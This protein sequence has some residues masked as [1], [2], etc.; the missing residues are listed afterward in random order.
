MGRSKGH[1]RS[2]KAALLALAT[3]LLLL[4]L[5][6]PAQADP[7]A[8]TRA[9]ALDVPNLNH[10]CGAA[11]DKQG[12]L[13]ASSAGESKVKVYD[14]AD[15]TTP[16]AE[17]ANANTPCALAVTTTGALY[18][19]E[20]ATGNVVRY[21]PTA[22]P[23]EA[24]PIYGPAEPIHTDG[25]A[26]GIA[27][28]PFDNR[29]FVA[30]GDRIALYKADGTLEKA[31]LLEGQLTEATGVA[32]YTNPNVE[33]VAKLRLNLAVADGAG[34]ELEIY[35]GSSSTLSL[36]LRKTVTGVDH[37]DNPGT[38]EQEFSFGTAGAY[39][40]ADRG[41]ENTADGKCI[42]V[43]VGGQDQACT[44][45]HFFLHD[46][47]NEAIDEFGASGEFFAQLTSS[48]LE[49]A[50]PTQVAVERSGGANDGTLYA[51]SGS[52]AG[53]SLL[54]FAPVFEP[55]RQSLPAPFSK[56]L[57]SARAVAVDCEGFVYVAAG[58]LVRVYS[59]AGAEVV[60]FEVPSTTL[61]LAADCSG[62]VYVVNLAATEMTYYPPSS[63]PPSGSTTYTRHTP[64]LVTASG[65]SGV[66]V[67]PANEHAF[68]V[69]GFAFTP[70]IKEFAPPSESS[71]VEGECGAGLGLTNSRQDID[72]YGKNGNVYVT[73]NAA[74]GILYVLKCG[75]EAKDA[76]LIREVRE[77]GGCDS[78]DT[79]GS[80]PRIAINQS[81]GNFVE[82]ANNQP[83]DV[84]REYDAFG[85]C[86]AQ[87][88]TFAP[89]AV[90]LRLALDNSCA[91]HKPPLTEATT[92][93]CADTYPS[94]GTAYVA[95]DSSNNT[96]QPFD[97]NAFG[98]LEYPEVEVPPTEEF[99]LKVNKGGSGTG[100]VTSSP[101]GISCDPTC[102]ADFEE[103]TE[104]TLTGSPGANSKAVVWSGCDSVISENKCLV[105]MDA[106]IEVTATFDLEQHQL[107]VSKTGSGTGK[108][109]SSPPGIDCGSECDELYEH[110]TVVTLSASP[111]AGSEFTGFSGA[112]TGATC[113]VTMTA[114]KSV[115]ANFDEESTTPKFL[116]S[117]DVEGT[118]SGTV[119]SDKGLIVCDPACTDEYEEGTVVVLT[120]T[121]DPGSIFVSWRYCD[122]GGVAGRKCTIT[123]SKAKAVKATFTTTHD[124]E[125]SKAPGSGLGKVQSS[126]GGILCLAT[127]TETSAAFKEG[128][129]VTLKPT[130]SK[131]FHFVQWSGDCTGTDPA[132]CKVTMGEDHEVEALFAEDAKH[133]LTLSKSGGGQG[134]VKSKPTSINCGLTCSTQ[135]S[136]FYAGEVVELTYTLGKGSEFG[137]WS[138]ACSGTGACAVTMSEAKGV[139]AEFK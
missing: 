82:Y 100:T 138:G 65:L 32:P 73:A 54:A 29:L 43:Q 74:A 118:G 5:A 72:V 105:T 86:I 91:L 89:N 51:G 106:D 139:T 76:E 6:A 42:Q 53:A 99:T 71:K 11:A 126:P 123:M 85:A 33:A 7:P 3:S 125:V 56:V 98:P 28:D 55:S 136:S 80:N 101:S 129:Q 59:P 9:K 93:T 116:L 38:A 135:T 49:D 77:G 137:G 60:N 4:A 25:D 48:A 70:I 67:N 57:A 95:N 79:G 124:L 107:S 69:G 114:A 52:G 45:G 10:A 15:H 21:K 58:T 50:E 41:N 22:F 97:V 44:Q 20:Q 88:G 1:R 27:T 115:T 133:L 47:G 78:G 92:P 134:T 127:C 12:D 102:E 16:I 66:A 83:G 108:V 34:D 40:A 17:I 87:F 117:V 24:T 26:E 120:A 14:A 30:A 96:V 132:G 90:G 130:P 131:H 122:T 94:N 113:E 35:S 112:C 128:T 84:A 31:D 61:D 2:A 119:T 110:G 111:D 103:D 68:V 75:K 121:P 8:H 37:D 104:V 13:Y 63:Y 19:S 18:V 36:K 64:A 62:N 81:N 46:A 23:L 109:T 39:L